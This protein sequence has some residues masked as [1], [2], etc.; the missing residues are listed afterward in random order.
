MQAGGGT[1]IG[2][3]VMVSATGAGLMSPALSDGTVARGTSSFPVHPVA[4]QIGGIS[5]E[6]TYAGADSQPSVTLFVQ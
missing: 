6:V 5:A 2:S 1:A 3:V 4:V